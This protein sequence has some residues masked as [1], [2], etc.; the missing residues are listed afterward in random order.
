MKL[1]KSRFRALMRQHEQ[2]IIEDA[3]RLYDGH[4]IKAAVWLEIHPESVRRKM[5]AFGLAR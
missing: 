1:P 2:A 3:L 5:V 4:P